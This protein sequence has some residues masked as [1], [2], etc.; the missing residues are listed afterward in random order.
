MSTPTAS[1][2]RRHV[3]AAVLAIK[4]AG[5]PIGAVEVAV[6]AAGVTVRIITGPVSIEAP[7]AR[8]APPPRH[9]PAIEALAQQ[10]RARAARRA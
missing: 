6:G 9:D 2:V 5:E 4:A 10:V 8:I 7:E 3:R 1:E